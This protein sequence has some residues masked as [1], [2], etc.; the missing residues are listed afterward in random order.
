MKKFSH[1]ALS[2]FILFLAGCNGTPTTPTTTTSTSTTTTSIATTTST[3]TST[4]TTTIPPVGA[5]VIMT[6]GPI[7]IDGY[8][9]FTYKGIVKNI[10]YAKAFNVK[11]YIYL[12]KTNGYL[13]DFDYTYI[14]TISTD[15]NQNEIAGWSILFPDSDHSKKNAMNKSKT[16]YSIQWQ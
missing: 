13:L 10:G 8:S 15:L 6:E 7:F 14:D 1:I 3:T 12:R 4:T 16:T 11:I 5:N 2:L 9:F